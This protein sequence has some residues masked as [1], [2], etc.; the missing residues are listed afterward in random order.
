MLDEIAFLSAILHPMVVHG[1]FKSLCIYNGKS[2]VVKVIV[3]I[4]VWLIERENG[5][6]SVKS[7]SSI[8][9]NGPSSVSLGFR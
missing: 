2:G 4:T 5:K 6:L 7:R 8:M 9:V 3:V 1:T